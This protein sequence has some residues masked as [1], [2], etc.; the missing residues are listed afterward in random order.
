MSWS[1]L[2]PPHFLYL[3]TTG[4]SE[5]QRHQNIL[6]PLPSILVDFHHL[7]IHL[8][9]HQLSHNSVYSS[10]AR[11]HYQPVAPNR[12]LV[13]GLSFLLQR[14]IECYSQGQGRLF[15]RILTRS[16]LLATRSCYFS[17]RSRGFSYSLTY[18]N[19]L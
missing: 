18:K 5:P 8:L 10:L 19:Q 2:I 14:E 3:R 17:I 11:E 7:H 16:H 9:L 15:P 12:V 4:S 6:I 1:I 13:A